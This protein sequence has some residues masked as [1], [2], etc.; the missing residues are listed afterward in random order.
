MF[1][2][3]NIYRWEQCSR[4]ATGLGLIVATAEG[5]GA[6]LRQSDG[7]A[8]LELIGLAQAGD[9]AAIAALLLASQRNIRRY[10][11][12]SCRLEDIDDAVQET[13]TIVARRIAMLRTPT[14]F[15]SWVFV[16]VSRECYRLAR[17]RLLQ[18][19]PLDELENSLQLAKRPEAE[20][21]FDLAAA[22]QSLPP[23][24]RSV[25]L[26]RDLEELSIAEIATATQLSG[27]A[28]KARLRRARL[29]IREY[30]TR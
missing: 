9:Q 12:R 19:Q 24:Y 2:R 3:K 13:L 17:S 15:V 28:V 30:L 5:Q 18:W 10:A 25:V 4:V 16:M 20:L 22:I 14:A 6:S 26:L 27:E 21:R 23:H 1:Y 29:M 11:R 8:S 7:E